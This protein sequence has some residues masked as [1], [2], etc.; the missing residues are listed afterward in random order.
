VRYT[1]LSRAFACGVS[2]DHHHH[3]HVLRE[4]VLGALALLAVQ[5]TVEGDDG[6][7]RTEER[8]DA[9]RE[10]GKR[11]PVLGEDDQLVA[12]PAR[13]EHLPRALQKL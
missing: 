6:L 4:E 2:G 13:V 11:V 5:A 10:I 8:A 3:I 12:M 7:G 9:L 1:S